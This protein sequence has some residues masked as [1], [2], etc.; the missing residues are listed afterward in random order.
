MNYI[1]CRKTKRNILNIKYNNSNIIIFIIFF[2]I[3]T[4]GESKNN[5][6][7]LNLYT[8]IMINIKGNGT[9]QILY[10]DFPL[11]SEIIVN[12]NVLITEISNKIYNLT[13]EENDIKLVFNESLIDCSYMFF[14]LT[15]ITKI[16]FI[17]FNASSVTN[18]GRMFYGCNNL[19]SL[20]LSNFNTSSITNMEYIFT[21][22]SKLISLD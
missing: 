11:P 5:I 17:Q 3:N 18:M 8:E 6:I 7:K 22:C 20:D 2:I 1:K 12:D 19:I 4:S 9:Q 16:N 10:K 14:G 21:Y 13:L 15:N